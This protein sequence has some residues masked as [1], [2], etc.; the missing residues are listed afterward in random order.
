MGNVL[1]KFRWFIA[2]AVAFAWFA[3]GV[4]AI[5][6][7]PLM[8]AIGSEFHREVGSLAMGIMALN[9]LALAVGMILI[10]PL[11]DKFGPRLMLLLSAIL[12]AASCL[13]IPVAAHSM[14][15][16]VILRILQGLFSAPVCACM[17]A[18]ANRWFPP[19]EQGT[20]NGLA[21]TRMGLGFALGFSMTPTVF[22]AFHENWRTTVMISALLPALEAV[23]FII[24]LMAKEPA[25]NSP[26]GVPA[27]TGNEF[28]IALKVP[29]FWIAVLLLI[30]AGGSVQTLNSLAMPYL[31][32]KPDASPA[33]VGLDMAIAGRAMSMQQIGMILSGLLVGLIMQKIFK[34]NTKPVAMI[35]SVLTGACS[36]SI[37]LNPVHGNFIVLSAALFLVGF[38]VSFV[39]PAIA[40]F[41]STNYPPQILGKVFA[42]TLGIASLGQAGVQSISAFMLDKTHSFNAIFFFVLGLSILAA[43]LSN[44]LNPVTAFT[45]L[46]STSDIMTK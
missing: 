31:Q 18:L 32:A 44:F 42:T 24:A 1:S 20:F 26:V 40:V 34:G 16:I 13:A 37:V 29:A 14:T 35:G 4:V 43:V 45:R 27:A 15:G 8:G 9:M 38:F 11:I 25:T 10:G 22:R 23:L 12:L 21:S 28:G 5:V 41:I 17:A 19:S 2:F 39:L 7:V 46:E 6:F 30:I 36:F 33:G 3:Y